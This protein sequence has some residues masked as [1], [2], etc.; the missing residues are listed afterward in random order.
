MDENRDLDDNAVNGDEN[1]P[2]PKHSVIADNV[3]RKLSE[4][5][6]E[7]D[8]KFAEV[9]QTLEA[10]LP[11]VKDAIFAS[12]DS[13][14]ENTPPQ[15]PVDDQ[16]V[17]DATEIPTNAVVISGDVEVPD[18]S[19]GS[20]SC[21][22]ET[23]EAS[24]SFPG[25]A[26]PAEPV[27]AE[28]GETQQAETPETPSEISEP[29]V[30]AP[31]PQP[32][33]PPPP[34]PVKI[35]DYSIIFRFRFTDQAG[36]GDAFL[37]V[38]KQSYVPKWLD[39][40]PLPMGDV[41]KKFQFGMDVDQNLNKYFKHHHDITGVEILDAR[42]TPAME[43]LGFRI[44]KSEGGIFWLTGNFED[45]F[46][47]PLYFYFTTAIDETPAEDEAWVETD[48][49]VVRGRPK[50]FRINPDPRSLWRDDPVA[51]YEGYENEDYTSHGVVFG[52]HHPLE[53]L[54]ASVRGR[55]HA[56]VGKPRDDSFHTLYDDDSGWTFVA[57]A[58]GAGSAKYSRKGSE[59]ACAT[60][61]ATLRSML[62]LDYTQTFM[63]EAG[64]VSQWRPAFEAA[65]DGLLE[66][67]KQT[68]MLSDEAGGALAQL[69]DVFHSAVHAAFMAIHDEVVKRR[70]TPGDEKVA[71]R[72]YHT[73]LL[74]AAIRYFPSQG[75]YFVISYWV[76]DGG[77]A[78]L[79]LNR[80]DDVRVLGEPDGGEFAGQTR[81]LTMSEEIDGKAIGNRLRFT[82][83]KDFETL[84]L[85]T[86]GITDPFFPSESAV[87]DGGKWLHFYDETLQTGDDANPGCKRLDDSRPP[88]EKAES[89]LEWLNF[90]SK[91]NHDDRT[92][93]VVR[94]K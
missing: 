69:R 29:D 94:P 16:N 47:G 7:T 17:D 30:Q 40:L 85:V 51:D 3:G 62:T 71:M 56:H 33:P 36:E 46:D 35:A 11:K 2:T 48:D 72:D 78:I 1:Q 19:Q 88:A 90:W 75:V 61:I 25:D 57:V 60:M 81:F 86:D 5:K 82:F 38:F 63:G 18:S 87:A 92:I 31:P 52:K 20:M 43:K 8:G 6:D 64:L 66:T 83:C 28:E 32:L 15:P 77:A 49:Y 84:L 89:L 91:G 22:T 80:T 55:S 59:L 37:K 4:I 58:D 44:T 9:K 70:A 39:W 42:L 10:N 79:R 93:L 14:N 76:G 12:Y 74:C 34:E 41:G 24:L 53:I 27:S 68:G 26:P 45:E 21:E 67:A 54:A 13:S 23:C 50:S 73:T 65:G